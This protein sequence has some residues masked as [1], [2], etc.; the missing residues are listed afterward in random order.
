MVENLKSLLLAQ[1]QCCSTTAIMLTMIFRLATLHGPAHPTSCGRQSAK[2]KV[3][4]F[5]E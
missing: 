3:L 4:L 1:G 2:T 5:A